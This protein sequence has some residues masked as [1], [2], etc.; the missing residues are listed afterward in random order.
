MLHLT[1]EG[2]LKGKTSIEE[3]KNALYQ[4]IKY[5]PR[6]STDGTSEFNIKGYISVGSGDNYTENDILRILVKYCSNFKVEVDEDDYYDR[7]FFS[8]YFIWDGKN[9][10]QRC[11]DMF[12]TTDEVEDW[13][14][15]LE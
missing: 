9:L 5:E 11:K 10:I 13:N 1:F 7:S 14:W 6:V 3:L 8:L 4:K 15:I 12:G 2:K